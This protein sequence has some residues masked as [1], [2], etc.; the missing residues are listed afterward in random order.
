MD[1]VIRVIPEDAVSHL[2]ATVFV[3]QSTALICMI[4]AYISCIGGLHVV[5]QNKKIYD[6]ARQN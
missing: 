6:T 2:R 4:V 1:F 3:V 5:T